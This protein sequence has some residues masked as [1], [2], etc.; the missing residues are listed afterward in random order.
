L[1]L[2]Y[3]DNYTLTTNQEERISLKPKNAK[4]LQDPSDVQ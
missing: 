2:Q 4:K 3:L 1:D